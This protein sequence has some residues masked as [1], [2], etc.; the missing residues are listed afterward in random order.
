MKKPV[1][2]SHI[3]R[4]AKQLKKENPTL[5]HHQALDEASKS[6]GHTNLKNYKNNAKAYKEWLPIALE[7]GADA[8]MNEQAERMAAKLNLVYPLFQSFKVPVQDLI[9]IFKRKKH[10]D[11]EIQ[12]ICEK[13]STLKEYLELFL[14]QDSLD[15]IDWDLVTIAPY[16]IPNHATVKNLVYKYGKDAFDEPTDA[17]VLYV[18]GEYEITCKIM[19]E[20]SQE[21]IN[22]R[23]DGFFDDRVLTGTF[24]L[25]ID[26][27]K[28]VT[29]EDIDIGYDW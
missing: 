2:L 23:N 9:D 15:D 19:F 29:I 4:K 5:K 20:H 22:S 12:S 21:D 28:N 6:F 16:H 27:N 10:S 17:D 26:K 3:Q 11:K 1:P 14:L 13:E 8:A 18:E 7:A 24:E 25:T